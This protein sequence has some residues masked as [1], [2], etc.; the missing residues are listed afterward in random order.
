M[1]NNIR[2]TG[3]YAKEIVQYLYALFAIY[4]VLY[5]NIQPFNMLQNKVPL[6]VSLGSM[7]T[8]QLECVDYIRDANR[9]WVDI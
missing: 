4:C 6:V 9:D 2:R 1:S 8:G 7:E 3:V 5:M